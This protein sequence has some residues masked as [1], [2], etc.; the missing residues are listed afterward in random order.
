MMIE[1]ETGGA[2]ISLKTIT[3]ISSKHSKTKKGLTQYMYIYISIYTYLC[4]YIYPRELIDAH[5]MGR[6]EVSDIYIYVNV[7]VYL[8]IHIYIYMYIHIIMCIYIYMYIHIYIYMYI[9][10]HRYIHI[11]I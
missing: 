11:Y 5:C 3:Y 10:M 2:V 8:Y 9:Y 1:A 6:R 4:I 7:Y